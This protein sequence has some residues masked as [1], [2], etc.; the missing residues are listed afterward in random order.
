MTFEKQMIFCGI[1]K[2]KGGR[3]LPFVSLCS[4]IDTA[5]KWQTKQVKSGKNSQKKV[6]GGSAI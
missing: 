2:F 6:R 5:K 1:F 3:G 4:P